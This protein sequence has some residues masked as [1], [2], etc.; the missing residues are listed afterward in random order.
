MTMT[1]IRRET[2]NMKLKSYMYYKSKYY[3]RALYWIQNRL[4]L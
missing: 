2:A 1:L 4:G 3:W